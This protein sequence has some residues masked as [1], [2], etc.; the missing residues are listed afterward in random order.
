MLTDWKI[1]AMVPEVL[2][3]WSA[4]AAR[5]SAEL[6]AAAQ[7]PEAQ[8]KLVPGRKSVGDVAV[9]R[10]GG[11]IAQKPS[12]FSMLFGGTSTEALVREL[13]AVMN[14]G[15]I[16]AVVLDVDSPGGEV[17]GLEEAAGAIRAMRGTKPL[18]AVANPLAAS[19][20][21]YLASQASDVAVTPSGLV[22]SIGVIAH[23]VD[24]SSRIERAGLRVTQVTYGRR[25]GEES[26]VGP[27]SDEARASIQARVDTYGRKFEAD[28]AKGRR[29]SVDKVRSQFGEGAL[30][31]A[32]DAKGVGLVDRVATLDEVIYAAARGLKPAAQA[33]RAF[34]PGALAAR[35]ILAGVKLE[36]EA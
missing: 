16:G 29:V 36:K 18:F 3:E 1:L 34:D 28:V 30:M 10:I 33:V 20:A 32:D 26:S 4:I 19:A 9:L 11:F 35:A 27:L 7:S 6:A 23:H 8:A 24:E 2:A 15:S 14:D 31:T 17:F 13:S 12:L 5:A 21:Y 22:G 25:K